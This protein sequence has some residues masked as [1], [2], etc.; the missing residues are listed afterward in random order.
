MKAADV[1]TDKVLPVDPGVSVADAARL[2]LDSNISGLPVVDRDGRLVGI[3]SEGDFLRRAETGT[4]RRR[5]RWLEFLL[6]PGR[7]TEEYVRT[8]GRKA[9]R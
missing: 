9:K 7:L 5:L 6:G 3:V 4:E 8:H 1:M 2:M